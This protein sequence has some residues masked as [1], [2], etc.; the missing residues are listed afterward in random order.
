LDKKIRGEIIVEDEKEVK[1]DNQRKNVTF[2][3]KNI[4]E[5]LTAQIRLKL[6][7][8]KTFS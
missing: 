7:Y 4:N 1:V 8:L 5:N 6:F 2:S 3:F